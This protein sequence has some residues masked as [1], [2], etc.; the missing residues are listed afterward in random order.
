MRWKIE[1]YFKILKSGFQLEASKLR[2]ASRLA[3]IISIFCILAWRI[4]WT[5]ILWR[6]SGR[7]ANLVL[8]FNKFELKVLTL[9]YKKEKPRRLGDYF[10]SKTGWVYQP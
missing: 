9:F 3:R 8:V 4:F 6:S 10:I 2:S 7:E 1:E 5:T